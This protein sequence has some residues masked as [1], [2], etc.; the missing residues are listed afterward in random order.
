MSIASRKAERRA[1]QE[2]EYAR[3]EQEAAQREAERERKSQEEIARLAA[4]T[5][6]ELHVMAVTALRHAEHGGSFAN[7]YMVYAKVSALAALA[8]FALQREQEE[9]PR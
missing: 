5:S 3:A 4:L 9:V 7:P 8:S 1:A 6:T 2:E